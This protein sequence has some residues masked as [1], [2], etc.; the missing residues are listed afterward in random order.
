MAA[1][2]GVVNPGAIH[3][4]TAALAQVHIGAIKMQCKST[5]GGS[6]QVRRG[7][8]EQIFIRAG[9]ARGASTAARA[10]DQAPVREKSDRI[11]VLVTCGK[12]HVGTVEV[13]LEGARC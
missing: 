5:T 11:D 2:G 8:G 3:I 10:D 1:G 13:Q 7:K 9:S 4:L 12:P 6:A